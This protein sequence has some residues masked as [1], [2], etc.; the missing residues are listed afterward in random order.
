[1]KI[2]SG[3]P[4][5]RRSGIL[6][7]CVVNMCVTSTESSATIPVLDSYRTKH[8]D[9]PNLGTI[10]CGGYAQYNRPLCLADYGGPLLGNI[11]DKFTLV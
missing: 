5:A 10:L 4:W 11:D 9:L 6:F 2:R 3:I 7:R 8:S 1:M